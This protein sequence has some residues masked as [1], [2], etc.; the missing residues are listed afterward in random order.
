MSTFDPSVWTG[1]APTE[2]GRY[3][4]HLRSDSEARPCF[5]DVPACWLEGD[6]RSILPI[7]SA[8]EIAALVECGKALSELRSAIEGVR[9]FKKLNFGGGNTASI[10]I[11]FME[12]VNLDN[13]LSHST[14]SLARL[15]AARRERKP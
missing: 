11:A 2:S 9:G 6:R 15:D 5:L 13:A 12:T 4:L 14:E 3:W 7:P 10:R 8:E 1:D